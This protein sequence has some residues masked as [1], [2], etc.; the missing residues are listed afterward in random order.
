MTNAA[1]EPQFLIVM[2]VSGSGKTTVGEGIAQTM[3]WLYAEGDDFHSQACVS[4]MA[5]GVPLTDEDRWPW[6]RSIGT[7]IDEHA[8]DGSSAVVTCSALKRVYRDLL[9]EGREHVRFV[10]L[11]VPKDVL[12]ERLAKRTGHYMPPSLL[13]SQLEALEPLQSDENGVVVH[14]H[15]AP[16][17]SVDEALQLLGLRP[18][19]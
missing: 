11:D 17:E 6:L 1:S 3:G 2:G 13:P 16:Q 4:K 10:F 9:R 12:E 5:S 7:W 15:R 8:R 19:E 14:A 18:G